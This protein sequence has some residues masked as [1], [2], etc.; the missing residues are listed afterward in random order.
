MIFTGLEPGGFEFGIGRQYRRVGLLLHALAEQVIHLADTRGRGGIF[1]YQDT[2]PI[3]E[4]DRVRSL[5]SRARLPCASGCT[6]MVSL[7]PGFA[8]ITPP[9]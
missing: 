1:P 9:K 2:I 5:N 7:L 3:G 6:G 4:V 8:S